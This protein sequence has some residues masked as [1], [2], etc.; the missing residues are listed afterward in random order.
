MRRALLALAVAL[1]GC[2]DLPQPFRHEGINT[3]LI[4]GAAR[5]V[6]VPRLDDGPRARALSDAIVARLLA[7]EIP[8]SGR[9]VGGS[10][11]RIVATA[12]EGEAAT[13]LTWGLTRADADDAADTAPPAATL[14]QTIPAGAWGR[15]SP[16]TVGL[17]ADEVVAAFAPT[18][19]PA[20][21]PGAAGEDRAAPSGPVAR[22]RLLPFGPLPGDGVDS[23]RRAL[24]SALAAQ[25]IETVEAETPGACT[26]RVQ[27]LVLPAAEETRIEATWIVLGPDGADLGRATQTGGVPRGRL[28]QPWGG[29]AADIARGGAE[30]IAEIVRASVK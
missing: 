28:D 21:D 26:V 4:P 2:G 16:R 24:L 30:G 20:P 27:V 12:E 25:G 7:D 13:R 23:L 19:R 1:G 5:A 22:V 3:A 18:L 8:A 14:T 9:P 15:A 17:I 6:E 29:L 11:W 10:A